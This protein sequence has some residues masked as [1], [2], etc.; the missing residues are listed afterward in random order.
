MGA[1]WQGAGRPGSGVLRA[2]GPRM[3]AAGDQMWRESPRRD[4]T[5]TPSSRFRGPLRLV[6]TE[7]DHPGCAAPPIPAPP[8][9]SC[10]VTQPLVLQGQWGNQP[11]APDAIATGL[12]SALPSPLA[13]SSAPSSLHSRSTQLLGGEEGLCPPQFALALGSWLGRLLFVQG[14][15]HQ[16]C[17][18]FLL[19]GLAG[20][21][22]RHS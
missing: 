8:G 15:G 13:S 11:T 17:P 18:L 6:S 12:S 20:R 4:S 1:R 2:E 14:G 9:P 3:K 22:L 21:N 16:S 5:A 19:L 10:L 7:N